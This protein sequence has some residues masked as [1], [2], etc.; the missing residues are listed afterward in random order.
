MTQREINRALSP[1]TDSQEGGR[2][3]VYLQWIRTNE[4]SRGKHHPMRIRRKYGNWA[5]HVYP[6]SVRAVRKGYRR[7]ELRQFPIRYNKNNVFVVIHS[8]GLAHPP[9]LSSEITKVEGDAGNPT[10]GRKRIT[11]RKPNPPNEG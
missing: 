4:L 10:R 11:R 7:P 6:R 8:P 3:E 5:P 1:F 2:Y 9:I